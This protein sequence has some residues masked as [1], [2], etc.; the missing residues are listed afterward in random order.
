MITTVSE[1]ATGEGLATPRTIHCVDNTPQTPVNIT[2]GF[3]LR[4]QRQD[5]FVDIPI[6]VANMCVHQATSPVHSHSETRQ[7]SKALEYLMRNQ[8]TDNLFI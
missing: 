2:P 5:K 7:I 4:F 1:V 6:R 8:R 3:Q